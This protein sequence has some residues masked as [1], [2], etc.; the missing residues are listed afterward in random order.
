MC[1]FSRFDIVLLHPFQLFPKCFPSYGHL[2]T[3][4]I[5]SLFT[6]AKERPVGLLFLARGFESFFLVFIFARMATHV[7]ACTSSIEFRMGLK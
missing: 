1:A 4:P 7:R 5:Q 2:F 3:K 6:R